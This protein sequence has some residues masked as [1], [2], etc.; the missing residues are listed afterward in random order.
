MRKSRDW[1]RA[2]GTGPASADRVSALHRV[3]GHFGAAGSYM[4]SQG[5][6]GCLRESCE[7]SESSGC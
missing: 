7:L 1:V 6:L 3:W 5:Q 4:F 2:I